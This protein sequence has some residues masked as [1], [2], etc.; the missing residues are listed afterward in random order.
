MVAAAAAATAAAI[1]AAIGFCASPGAGGVAGNPA[2][3]LEGIAADAAPTC[4]A[5]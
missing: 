5:L 4:V 1:A 2:K 3:G